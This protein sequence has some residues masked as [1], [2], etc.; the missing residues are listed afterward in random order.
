MRSLSLGGFVFVAHTMLVSASERATPSRS[1]LALKVSVS[2][3]REALALRDNE[4]LW[5]AMWRVYTGEPRK[6]TES[7]AVFAAY[8]DSTSVSEPDVRIMLLRSVLCGHLAIKRVVEEAD[9]SEI[10][11]YDRLCSGTTFTRGL[12]AKSGFVG[13]DDKRLAQ[14]TFFLPGREVP[15]RSVIGL[16]KR[17]KARI[18]TLEILA[19]TATGAKYTRVIKALSRLTGKDAEV[20]MASI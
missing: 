19:Q 8:D 12:G 1:E 3:F 20:L 16:V 13:I 9:E 5:Q 2:R 6:K 14:Y 17:A 15:S 4:K 11:M 10:A 18:E 7:G